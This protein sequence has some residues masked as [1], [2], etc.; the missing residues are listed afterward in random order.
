MGNSSSGPKSLLPH[1]LTQSD[2][3]EI[4]GVSEAT[5]Q[6]YAR[7]LFVKVIGKKYG[8]QDLEL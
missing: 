7:E 5:I 2:F 4:A 1:G 6:K 3:A 8:V